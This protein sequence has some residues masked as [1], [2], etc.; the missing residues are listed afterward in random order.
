MPKLHSDRHSEVQPDR[1]MITLG[2]KARQSLKKLRAAID[3]SGQSDFDPVVREILD[4]KISGEAA[5]ARLAI[6]EMA[7]IA[8]E[9]MRIAQKYNR[10]EISDALQRASFDIAGKL[11]QDPPS[12][13]VTVKPKVRGVSDD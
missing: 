1:V 3:S 11:K 9:S 13:S 7:V 12:I 5:S 8:S 4:A 10:P 2:E 6:F